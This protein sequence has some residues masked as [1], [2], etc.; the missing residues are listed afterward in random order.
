[1]A[2]DEPGS[3]RLAVPTGSVTIRVS[4][5]GKAASFP[6]RGGVGQGSKIR[7]ADAAGALDVHRP[8][9][10]RSRSPEQ[11]HH[12]RLSDSDVPS[13]S[14]VARVVELVSAVRSTSGFRSPSTPTTAT[15]PSTTSTAG[16]AASGT[17][18]PARGHVTCAFTAPR[19]PRRGSRAAGSR[20]RPQRIGRSVKYRHGRVTAAQGVAGARSWCTCSAASGSARTRGRSRR[21]WPRAGRRCRVGLLERAHVLGDLGV[22]GGE[23]VDAALPGPGLL[24]QV[25]ERDRR[26]RAGPRPGRAARASPSGTAAGRRSAA[27]RPRTTRRARPACGSVL[28]D[29]D[30]AG[31]ALVRATAPGRAAAAAPGRTRRRSPAPAGCAG[32]RRAARRATTTSSTPSSSA[33]SSSSSQNARQR[34]LGSMPR[35]STMSRPAPA[36]PGQR[37]PR[38]GPGESRVRRRRRSRPAA[39]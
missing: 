25:A 26:C 38:G 39:G 33:T 21:R 20:C 24:G 1:M 29:A 19:D 7:A 3:G 36:R 17:Y 15:A 12:N 28:E 5:S 22:L 35:I 32:R 10:A 11:R 4:C 18:C 31:R 16:R 23:L 2:P 8:R 13:C 27:P 14:T 9:L 30:D 37:D 34:M 6:G